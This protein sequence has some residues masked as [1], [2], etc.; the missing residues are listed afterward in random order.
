MTIGCL[1]RKVNTQP[2]ASSKFSISLE[3]FGNIYCLIKVI[4]TQIAINQKVIYF[5]L[6]KNFEDAKILKILLL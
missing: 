2:V 5:F 4:K 1:Q 6:R 3:I